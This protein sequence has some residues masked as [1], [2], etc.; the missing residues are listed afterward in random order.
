MADTFGKADGREDKFHDEDGYAK[1]FLEGQLS[2][3][4]LGFGCSH[5]YDAANIGIDRLA[6]LRDAGATDTV[7]E[8]E[9]RA[10]DPMTQ[11]YLFVGAQHAAFRVFYGV[12]EM[13][14]MHRDAIRNITLFGGAMPPDMDE[15]NWAYEMLYAPVAM[16][17]E[18]TFARIFTAY[19]QR[20]ETLHD[21]DGNLRPWDYAPLALPTSPEEQ[22]PV[23]LSEEQQRIVSRLLDW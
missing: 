8:A 20:H 19:Q 17:F 18:E 10:S 2:L 5:C 1:L 7:I 13:W 6:Q 3:E 16:R 12:K 9:L 15:D 4:A 11:L 23:E 21:E 22:V 14:R